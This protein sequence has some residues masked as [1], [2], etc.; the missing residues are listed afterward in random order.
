MNTQNAST[1]VRYPVRPFLDLSTAH[2]SPATHKWLD[3][4]C[5]QQK[6]GDPGSWASCTPFGW[7]LWAH[8][9]ESDLTEFPADLQACMLK[10]QA[11]GCHYILFDRDAA[12]EGASLD[13]PWYGEETDCAC[14][15][16]SHSHH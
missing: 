5:A 7:F 12:P 3:D 11:L 15:V 4:V 6:R 1:A 10:A 9:E 13:L 2:L 16:D 8:D 14:E